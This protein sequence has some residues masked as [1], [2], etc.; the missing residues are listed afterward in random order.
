M[1]EIRFHSEVNLELSSP[2]LPGCKW[3]L[4]MASQQNLREA[5]VLEKFCVNYWGFYF[6]PSSLTPRISATFTVSWVEA[7]VILHGQ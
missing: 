1:N 7:K 6:F 4:L 2:V 5:T 3:E